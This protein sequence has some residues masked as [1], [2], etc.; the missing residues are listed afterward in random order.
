MN[1]YTNR[2]PATMWQQLQRIGTGIGAIVL[3]A[4]A[5]KLVYLVWF[6]L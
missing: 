3:A 5:A 6:V 1:I 2:Q 4:T